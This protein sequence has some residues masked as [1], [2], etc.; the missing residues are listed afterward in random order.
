MW[1]DELTAPEFMPQSRRAVEEFKRIGRSA[2]YEKQCV[3]PDGTRWWDIFAATRLN[4][5]E[6]VEF[7]VDVTAQKA[8]EREREALLERERDARVEAER[9]TKL[10]ERRRGNP[11]ARSALKVLPAAFADDQ[12]SLT[13]F[14]R[15]AKAASALN[16]PNIITIH[17]IGS[18]A[19]T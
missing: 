11:R 12:D 6:G 16:P 14:I 9:A 15:E 10:R 7:V 1:W 4:E 13:R 17:D 3:R 5:R 2:P 19:G 18:A 8:A